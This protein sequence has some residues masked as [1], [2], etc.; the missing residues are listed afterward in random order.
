MTL[1]EFLDKYL[2]KIVGYPEGQFVGE[3]LSV[4]KL[5]IKECFGIDPPPS[6]TNSAYGYWSKFPDPLGTVFEKVDNTP[7]LI[8]QEGWIAVWKPWAS[9]Q[10]GHIAI[11]ASG[12]TTGTLMNY[13]QN[14]TSKVF[15]LESNRYTNVIGFLKPKSGTII[16][17]TMTD[18][19]KRIL[20]F[21]SEG[22]IVDKVKREITEGDVRQGI[23]YIS[24]NTDDKISKLENKVDTLSKKVKD[25][26]DSQL[27]DGKSALDWHS[28]YD[29]ASTELQNYKIKSLQVGFILTILSKN[30]EKIVEYVKSLFK[31]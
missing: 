2:G 18:K 4:C 25:L 28:E 11:V 29:S 30:K 14:W 26:T 5:Y 1:Q 31:K 15:Q 27:Y 20:K 7:D 3:C 23:G 24:S 17:D 21:I 9:N 19:E 13:A 12:C 8:P 6:G 16:S 22:I 10:Y